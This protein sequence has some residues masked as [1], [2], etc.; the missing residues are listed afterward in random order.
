MF[1]KL[2]GKI[3]WLWNL[4]YLDWRAVRDKEIEEERQA[5]T[6]RAIAHKAER[7]NTEDLEKKYKEKIASLSDEEWEKE[8]CQT[9]V[10]MMSGYPMPNLERIWVAEAAA[11]N[12]KKEE[13]EKSITIL[14][15]AALIEYVG[16][17]SHLSA[18]A[19]ITR[20]ARKELS[21][22]VSWRNDLAYAE[23]HGLRN[24]AGGIVWHNN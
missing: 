23:K 15:D 16:T 14:S 13:W 17:T 10:T 3:S 18:P 19:Y 1:N 11:R 9:Y 4:S 20:F 8:P 7:C 12:K 2:I 5:Y 6:A 24:P 21:R 22:R